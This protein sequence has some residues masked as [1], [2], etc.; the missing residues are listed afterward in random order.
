MERQAA[1]P[2]ADGKVVLGGRWAGPVRAGAAVTSQPPHPPRCRHPHPQRPSA[3]AAVLS[4][5]LSSAGA[6]HR[7]ADPLQPGS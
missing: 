7:G 3:A 6:G 2:H 5:P 1:A 4:S